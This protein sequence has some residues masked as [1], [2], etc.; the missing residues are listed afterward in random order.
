MAASRWWESRSTV[1]VTVIVI[2]LPLLWPTIPPLTDLPAHMASYRV[3]LDLARSPDLQRYFE[4]HWQLLGNAGVDLLVVPLARLMGLEAATKLIV[5]AIPTVTAIGF[6]AIAKQAHGRVPPTALAALPLACNYPLMFGFVN[7]SLSAAM[8]ML[9]FALWLKLSSQ[10]RWWTR[11]AAFVVI[12]AACWLAHAIGWVMLATLCGAVELHRRLNT[13]E[14]VVSSLALTALGCLPLLTPAVLIAAGPHQHDTTASGWF[15]WFLIVKWAVTLL[16]DRWLVFD[17]GSALLLWA[18]IAA[19]ILRWGGLR[20]NPALAWTAFALAILYVASPQE[21]SGSY[22]VSA[23]I[24]PYMVAVMVLAIDAG[25]LSIVR[26]QRLALAAAV[27]LAVRVG[28]NLTSFALYNASYTRELAA[29][30]QVPRGAAVLTFSATPC[31]PSISNWFTPRLYHLSGMAVVR[32][33]AFV[34][35]TW[36]IAGLHM[37]NVRYAEAGA[38][39]GDPSE[40][41]VLTPCP[42]SNNLT[43]A[44]SLARA[45]LGAF[46][47]VW[48][49]DMPS[50]TW[51]HDPRLKPLWSAGNSILYAVRKVSH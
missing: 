9:G 23:R 21:I 45:P 5:L 11:S 27:F 18:L 40:M 31:K 46:D 28:A 50:E 12:A 15:D 48:L 29:I 3:S 41:V 49:V 38:F 6:L 7:Y 22:F 20:F 43:L 4:F 19:A 26:Q 24:I 1:V 32:R 51:P 16:R 8:A 33:D 47:R 37:L 10:G 17:F 36:G 44:Q 42:I 35:A 34:N 39:Q 2:A 13:D 25:A 14:G 30:D